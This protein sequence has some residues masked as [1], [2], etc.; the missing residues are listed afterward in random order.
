M[1]PVDDSSITICASSVHE[2]PGFFVRFIS[3]RT[4]L[5]IAGVES[6]VTSAK[7]GYQFT[8]TQ[9]IVIKMLI[10]FTEWQS[11]QVHK[12]VIVVIFVVRI[13]SS[14]SGDAPINTR[15]HFGLRSSFLGPDVIRVIYD[16]IPIS[17]HCSIHTLLHM[18]A[19]LTEAPDPGSAVTHLPKTFPSIRIIFL[20]MF[21]QI[22]A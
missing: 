19:L 8:I 18:D 4:I 13:D 3:A 1:K 5:S 21:K 10:S 22:Y 20:P 14:T 7:V 17:S 11:T 16:A 15:A 6:I 12:V 9:R 2:Y